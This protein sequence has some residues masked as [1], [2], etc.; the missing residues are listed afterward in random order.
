M[1]VWPNR[2]GLSTNQTWE[3]GLEWLSTSIFPAVHKERTETTETTKQVWIFI[4][5]YMYIYLSICLYIYVLIYLIIHIYIYM[6]L[7]RYQ[8]KQNWNMSKKHRDRIDGNGGILYRHGVSYGNTSHNMRPKL[9]DG[10][11]HH[12]VSTAGQIH[13]KVRQEWDIQLV[14]YATTTSTFITLVYI[15]MCISPSI[16]DY[17]TTTSTFA[18]DIHMVMVDTPKSSQTWRAGN[19]MRS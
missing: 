12:Q 7:I 6:Y 14:I 9:P 19:S 3:W 10:G 8:H 18:G 1:T 5:I 11:T 15:T 13:E 4:Y 2:I 17:A 16:F